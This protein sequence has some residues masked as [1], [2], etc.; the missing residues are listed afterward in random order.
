MGAG[1]VKRLYRCVV[2]GSLALALVACHG[3]AP[4]ILKQRLVPPQSQS[5]PYSVVVTVSNTSGGEGQ[6]QLTARLRSAKTGQTAA[7][8]D[9]TVDL[10]PYETEE[11]VLQLQP[12]SQDT[13]E[14][15]VEVRYPPQ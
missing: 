1:K 6:I 10:R 14:T 12:A 2:L 15:S 9:Q 3:P 11:V 4:V 13:Y 5:E 7:E 8:V